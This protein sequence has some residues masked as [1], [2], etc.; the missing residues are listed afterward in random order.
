MLK[1]TPVSPGY[2]AG[3]VYR[4]F[5]FVPDVAE[6]SCPAERRA[7]EQAAFSA[8]K[9]AAKDELMRLRTTLPP[10]KAAIFSAHMEILEDEAI[11]EEIETAICDD[12]ATA[13]WA[14]YSV[15]NTF[16]AVLSRAKNAMI[17]ERTA[18]LTDVRNRLIRN[19]RHMP[20][21]NL[22]VLASPVVIASRDLLPSDAAAID[23]TKVL[24]FLTET[25]GTTSHAAILAR[26]FEIPAVLGI[27]GLMD[28]LADGEPVIVD[29]LRGEVLTGSDA[30]TTAAYENKRVAYQAK[31]ALD[32][33]F[34]PKAPV[35]KDGLHIA[36]SLN[37]GS[38]DLPEAAAYCDGVGLFRSEF[39]Y[40]ETDAQPDEETQFAA[41]ST[42]LRGMENRPV[43]L[44]TLDI[45]GDKT[46]SYLPLEKEDN[47]FLGV[48]AI[49]LC[50]EKQELFR[51]QLRAAL[52]ASVFG[53]LCLMFP[54]IGAVEDFRLAKRFYETVRSELAAKNVP[55]AKTIPV[56]AMIEIPAAAE[57]ADLLA[58]ETDFASIGTNDLCQYLF[59]ADRMNPR[60]APYAHPLSPAMLRLIHRT[61]KAY[62]QAGKPLSVCGELAGDPAAAALLIGC[63]VKKLSMSA[64]AVGAVKRL[65]VSSDTNELHAL[66]EHALTLSTEEEIQKVADAFL[67]AHRLLDEEN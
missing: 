15:M 19:L 65:I 7:D 33:M 22:S 37:I 52:R 1:G 57:C 46:L 29:G 47:P 42:A 9:S 5:P 45:G 56:G 3:A 11:L 35:T 36:V 14:V 50:L 30:E 40:M 64:S 38:P 13:E 34:V 59:A 51:T 44:R 66:A 21:K 62:E 23:R 17:R 63:G 25:G 24:A 10:D 43:L 48:R 18:D 31:R 60:V 8:A 20:E 61:A 2:A 26:S 32:R 16:I 39:L 49:R 6:T 53:N 58:R 67:R 54:M 28:G 4:Y 41:Y 27:P 55:M 12:G